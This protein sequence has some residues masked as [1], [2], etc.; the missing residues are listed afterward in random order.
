MGHHSHQAADN[1]VNLLKKANHDLILVQLKLEK[2]FQQVYPDN[3]NPMKLVNRIKKIQED[4]SIL[5]EQCGELLA[6]KQDL[7]DKARTSLVGN[8]NQIQRMQASVRIPLTTV[9]EDPAFANFNQIIDEWTAQVRSRTGDEGQNSESE[10]INNL[11]FSAIVHS[12]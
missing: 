11:L 3:A 1:V 10:D 4:L 6:A 2:E 7:I 8:R 5:K 9:D 12:N